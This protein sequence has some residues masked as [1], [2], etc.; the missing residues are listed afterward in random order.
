MKIARTNQRVQWHRWGG[1]LVEDDAKNIYVR[2]VKKV[3][4]DGK[5]NRD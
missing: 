3:T 5:K 1:G 4:L 2:G